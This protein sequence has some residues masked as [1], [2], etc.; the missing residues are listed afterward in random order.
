MEFAEPDTALEKIYSRVW[1]KAIKKYD[2]KA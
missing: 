2:W 1:R